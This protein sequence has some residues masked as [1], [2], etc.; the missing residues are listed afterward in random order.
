[1]G[2][3]IFCII[4]VRLLAGIKV[5]DIINSRKHDIYIDIIIVCLNKNL[6]SMGLLRCLI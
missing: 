4:R 3:V 1:M 6:F 5:N 2:G